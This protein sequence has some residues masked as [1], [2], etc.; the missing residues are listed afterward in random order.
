M[1]EKTPR[2][3]VPALAIA[4]APFA[5]QYGRPDLFDSYRH[6]ACVQQHTPDHRF[7]CF[8]YASCKKS[9]SLWQIQSR[10]CMASVRM[11]RSSCMQISGRQG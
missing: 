4:F 3:P 9:V 8:K 1:P 6:A 11:L 2:A 7:S 10:G 5:W